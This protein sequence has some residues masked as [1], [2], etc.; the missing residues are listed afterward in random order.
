M[1]VLIGNS[2]YENPLLKFDHVYVRQEN[3]Y[4]VQY[5]SS[6]IN[7]TKYQILLFDIVNDIQKAIDI[8]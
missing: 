6:L 1:K 7:R 4:I 2:E 8:E 5:L 3:N